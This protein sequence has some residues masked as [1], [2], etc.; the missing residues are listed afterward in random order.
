MWMILWFCGDNF[1]TESEA[2]A[3]GHAL[4]H[5]YPSGT[6]RIQSA[7]VALFVFQRCSFLHA[8]CKIKLVRNVVWIKLLVIYEMLPSG[9][10][11]KKGKES[12]VSFVVTGKMVVSPTVYSMCV[13]V[14]LP[15]VLAATALFAISLRA[16]NKPLITSFLLRAKKPTA[17]KMKR[18]KRKVCFCCSVS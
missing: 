1:A 14:A 10:F 9:I 17:Q 15:R 4:L 5:F 16:R 6:S 12:W 7:Y 8:A 13:H 3:A 11:R 2:M 18:R